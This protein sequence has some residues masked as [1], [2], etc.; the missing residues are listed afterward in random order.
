MTKQ[1]YDNNESDNEVDSA[2]NV[3]WCIANPIR[4][5]G[6][7]YNEN[8]YCICGTGNPHVIYKEAIDYT[9][10]IPASYDNQKF[11]KVLSTIKPAD[12]GVKYDQGKSPLSILTKESLKAEA[13]ALSYGAAKYGKN[14]YKKGMDWCRVIDACMRHLVA[15]NSKEDIDSESGLSH[16]AHAKAN[17][18][19]LIYYYENKVGMDNR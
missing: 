14:N 1:S 11:E 16:L 2:G 7:K 3:K 8:G 4:E 10:P 12:E 19:I 15:F 17:L 13:D 9:P 5:E 18:A 6:H